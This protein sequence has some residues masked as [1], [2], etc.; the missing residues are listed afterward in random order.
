MK[1]FNNQSV[2]QTI[3]ILGADIKVPNSF[4]L[5]ISENTNKQLNLIIIEVQQL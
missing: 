1:Q 3:A 2:P 4:P 5:G